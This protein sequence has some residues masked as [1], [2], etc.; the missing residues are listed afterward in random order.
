MIIPVI[1]GPTC[2][3]KTSLALR[4]ADEVKA[5][6][7]SID[8]RQVYRE[9]DIGTGKFKSNDDVKKYNGY[10]EINGKSKKSA[11]SGLS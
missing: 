8:S 6:I 2:I 4:I 9:L 10:W 3:G 5:D 1:L 7:L 11:T